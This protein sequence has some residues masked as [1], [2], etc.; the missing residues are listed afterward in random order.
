M[1]GDEAEGL[2]EG[3]CGGLLRLGVV[4]VA[5]GHEAMVN[6]QVVGGLRAGVLSFVCLKPGTAHVVL[7]G[8]TLC[9]SR[10]GEGMV[11]VRHSTATVGAKAQ[12]GYTLCSVGPGRCREGRDKESLH[13]TYPLKSPSP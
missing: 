5:P 9:I 10:E 3:V 7:L 11:V 12:Q 2:L 13:R 4:G 8:V 6:V 1:C